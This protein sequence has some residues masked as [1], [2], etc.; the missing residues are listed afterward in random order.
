MQEIQRLDPTQVVQR[1]NSHSH[2]EQTAMQEI[3]RMDIG[4]PIVSTD[5]NSDEADNPV[6]RGIEAC[7][8]AGP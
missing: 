8:S 4:T 6:L 2:V 1:I 3:Q 7:H 5:T